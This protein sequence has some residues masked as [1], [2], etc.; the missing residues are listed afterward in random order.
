MAFT[1][2]ASNLHRVAP[3][4]FTGPFSFGAWFKPSSLSGMAQI[5][6]LEYLDIDVVHQIFIQLNARS[7]TGNLDLYNGS[8]VIANAGAFT[9]D[10]Q[11]ALAVCEL[12]TASVFRNG[13]AKASGSFSSNSASVVRLTLGAAAGGGNCDMAEAAAWSVALSDDE[14]AAL[15]K[16]LSPLLVRPQSL[17]FYAPLV[18]EVKDVRRAA[19]FTTSGTPTVADHPRIFYPPQRRTFTPPP[20]TVVSVGA[21]NTLTLSAQATLARQAASASNSIVFSQRSFPP[22]VV[23]SAANTLDL[24]QNQKNNNIAENDLTLEQLAFLSRVNRSV[25]Q[26]LRLKQLVRAKTGN[27]ASGRYRR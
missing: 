12:S 5:F 14:A 26:T 3:S 10:W 22:R 15:G 18:R 8:T 27:I 21:I 7:V 1:H 2:S 25:E 16:G 6:S 4:A 24:D 20:A 17:I 13:G 9:A 11:H 23:V 19:T